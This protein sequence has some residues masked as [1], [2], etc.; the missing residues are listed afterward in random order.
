[1]YLFLIKDS[2]FNIIFVFILI[3]SIFVENVSI[4]I[5][6][7]IDELKRYLLMVINRFL[8]FMKCILKNEDRE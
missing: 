7:L 2:Y 1:M 8:E 6:Y 4:K 5:L 3:E